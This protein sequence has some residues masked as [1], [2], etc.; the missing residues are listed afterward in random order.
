MD[1]DDLGESGNHIAVPLIRLA[2]LHRQCNC[3]GGLR[4]RIA[5]SVRSVNVIFRKARS[6][7]TPPSR[8]H[9]AHGVDNC[10]FPG[11]VLPDKDRSL[12]EIDGEVLDRPKILNVE[13]VNTHGLIRYA[14]L[15]ASGRAA[16][17]RTGSRAIS[18]P[19]FSS[20]MR[21]S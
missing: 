17:A 8:Q 3:D 19:A 16:P 15:G 5:I 18:R 21:I 4:A 10:S 13:P 6:A 1:G 7:L 12:T 2:F 14:M 9:D 20:A 11:I